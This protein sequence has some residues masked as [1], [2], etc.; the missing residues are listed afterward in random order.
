MAKLGGLC[1]QAVVS[2]LFAE[3]AYVLH[4]PGRTDCLVV[5]PG[6]NPERILAAVD[7][8][9]LAVAAILITHG[10]ADHIA[11]NAAVKERFPGAPLIVGRGDA[12]K[13]T[14]P[15]LNL[16][17]RFGCA[18][19]SPPADRLVD[20]GESLD[21][22]GIP[23]EIFETPGHSAGHV[24][25]VHRGGSPWLVLGGDVLFQGSVGRTDIPGG[26]FDQLRAAIEQKLFVLPDDTIVLPGH[27]EPTTI[28]RERRL[29][30]F[31]GERSGRRPAGA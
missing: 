22:A 26:S 18:V 3:N 23:L 24:V 25:F 7:E 10:H 27:G 8:E 21:F 9:R 29:N 5:D 30:P 6:L 16:S 20:E 14:D 17:A 28:G 13:L 2:D 19:T 12:A 11:G 4:L 1:V 15:E 31:V